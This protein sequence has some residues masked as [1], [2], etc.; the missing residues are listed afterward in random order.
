MKAEN[1]NIDYFFLEE[2][3]QRQ[4]VINNSNET[5][6]PNFSLPLQTKTHKKQPLK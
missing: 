3:K 6:K 5:K 4:N 1:E 2:G